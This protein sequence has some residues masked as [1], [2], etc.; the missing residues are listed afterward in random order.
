MVTIDADTVGHAVLQSDGPA[1]AEVADRW[2]YVVE[3]GEINR[4]SLAAVVFDDPDELRSL[5]SITHPH[6]FDRIKTQVEEIDTAVVVEI[7]LLSHGLGDEWRRI[8]VDCDD[9]LRLERAISRGLTPKEAQARMA[10][11]PS[12]GE[13]LAAAD[14]VVPN[15]GS[16]DELE[17]TV[18]QLASVL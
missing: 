15:R 5:E 7:P 1:F 16:V 9:E 13:W 8:V 12:R 10:V 3:N 11:Q 17:S 2:P 4:R 18:D 14:L 6:I